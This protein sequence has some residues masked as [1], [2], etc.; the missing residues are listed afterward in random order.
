MPLSRSA[1]TSYGR[2]DVAVA[3]RSVVVGG[4]HLVAVVEVP[5]FFRIVAEASLRNEF[6]RKIAAIVAVIFVC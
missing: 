1:A 5:A 6:Q 4:I 2:L 3:R